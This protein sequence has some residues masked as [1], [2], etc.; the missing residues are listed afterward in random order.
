MQPV[1]AGVR[2]V[3]EQ[4]QSYPA[5]GTQG[6]AGPETAR[7]LAEPV[8]ILLVD[9]HMVVRAGLAQ[10]V[11]SVPGLV[12]VAEAENGEEALFQCQRE[13]PDV[14]LMDV[15]MQGMGGIAATE[16]ICR[17]HPNIAVIGLSSFA[18]PPTVARMLAAGARG[19]LPKS[20]LAGDL[21]AAIRRVH[22]GETVVD[23]GCLPQVATA[24]DPTT[25]SED[26][27]ELS[28]QQRRVLALLSKGYTNPEIAKYLGISMPTAR[29]HVSAILVK[30]GVSNRAEAAAM[31]IRNRLV[32]NSDF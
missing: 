1:G 17:Y 13:R 8:R 23:P 10:V 6:E 31:A 32:S 21:K 29:Y 12:V 15:R 11:G 3:E 22:H 19:F 2:M 27:L 30:L 28:A 25:P 20:V 4:Q 26:D 7:E 14:V 9:D 18:D 16:A 24:F 5:D